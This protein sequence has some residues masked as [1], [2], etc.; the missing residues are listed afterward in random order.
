M[1]MGMNIDENI[2]MDDILL[3]KIQQ[4]KLDAFNNAKQRAIDKL[5]ERYYTRGFQLQLQ[6]GV[7]T[8][9][10]L[11]EAYQFC[12]KEEDIEQQRVDALVEEKGYKDKCEYSF[13][14]INPKD[15]YISPPDMIKEVD[16]I[17]EKTKWINENDY[18]YVIE[19]RSSVS[20]V[21]TGVHAH[22]LV[23][24]K[25]KPNN[26]IRREM[27]NKVKNLVDMSVVE[28]FNTGKNRKGPLS[29]LPTV[30][31]ENRL[32][33]MLD[34]KKDPDKHAKQI[35]D[36]EM[37]EKF[38]IDRIYFSGEKISQFIIGHQECQQQTDPNIQKDQI[39]DIN[40]NQN[41]LDHPAGSNILL[42]DN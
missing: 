9:E 22:M 17:I 42:D 19:Q 31:P 13:I 21:Y 39:E 10:Y 36:N 24:T 30:I 27:K 3:L 32:S 1:D 34:W 16:K 6:R 35:I 8:N 14:T 26:E 40:E 37:R 25:D 7:C 18:C 11:N 12:K 2:N 5:V 33:Y 29:I 20:G 15:E 4:K 23:H 28:K 41:Q 38:G